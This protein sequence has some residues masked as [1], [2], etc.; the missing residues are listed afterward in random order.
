[1]TKKILILAL[2]LF[3][4]VTISPISV[5]AAP[6]DQ[7]G[8]ADGVQQTQT[9]S[10][11]ATYQPLSASNCGSTKTQIVSCGDAQTGTGTINSM[12]SMIISVMTVLI[13]VIATGGLAYAAIIYASAGDDQSK[14][15]E[16]RVI[17]RNVIV[18]LVLYGLTIGIISW[19]LPSNVITPDQSPDPSSSIVPTNS[20]SPSTSL[21][22]DQ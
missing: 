9:Q 5:S 18:G 12:I 7:T 16:A 19:L 20:V 14:V 4:A 2:T 17:I 11:P 10:P 21:Q 13:G 8:A 15:S 3:G 1:M 6:T 22:T